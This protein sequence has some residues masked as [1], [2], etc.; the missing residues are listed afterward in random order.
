MSS[1]SILLFVALL[2]IILICLYIYSKDKN[3]EPVGLLIKL[4]LLGII[5]C[6]VTLALTDAFASLFPRINTN[7]TEMSFIEVLFYAFFIVA[8]TEEI[9][10]WLM[11][12]FMGYKDKEFNELYDIIV[13]SVFVSLGFACFENVLY[14]VPSG[15]LLTGILRAVVSVPGH[16]CDAIAMGYFLS[17]AK[18]YH[19]KGQKEL[20]KKNIYLSIIIPSILHG[21][22]DY[23]LMSN[24]D[25]L[26]LVFILFI[27]L[28]YFI[29]IKRLKMVAESNAVISYKNAYC[30]TCGKKVSGPF[31]KICGT[32]Q[33]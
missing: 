30:P 14:V 23:C 33:V 24:I 9:S 28:L 10:K 4:F 29:S 20:E 19:T 32:R 21:I 26:L 13:Y 6:F 18:I 11:V 2:P 16:A 17:I 7:T 31:C 1:T 25:I 3:K 27:I 15:N 5:S 22:Y 8:L 12:Y